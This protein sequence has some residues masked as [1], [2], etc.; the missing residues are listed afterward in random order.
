MKKHLK[1]FLERLVEGILTLSGAVTS[2]TILL[3]VIFLFKE[4]VGLFNS[5]SIEKGYGLYTHSDNQIDD[6]EVSE[7]KD[8]FDLNISN[9]KEFGGKDEEIYLFRFNEI[10][11]LYT[12]AE[13]GENY[14]LIREKLEEFILENPTIIAYLP[15]R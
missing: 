14:T 11:K 10:F 13:L 9:W 6:L 5:P 7:I 12:D 1:K 2:I 3:I 15:I 8:I 4:G